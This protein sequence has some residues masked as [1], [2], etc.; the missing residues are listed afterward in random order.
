METLTNALS[1]IIEIAKVLGLNEDDLKS[2]KDFL[3]HNEFGLCFD[4]IVTQVYEFDIEI[5]IAFYEAISKIGNKMN[6]PIE[7]YSFMIELIR[8]KNK[9][10]KPVKDELLR[11]IESLEI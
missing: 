10:P 2:A 6:L 7:S 1:R 11:I 4:T 5:D 8:N 9:I 3:D